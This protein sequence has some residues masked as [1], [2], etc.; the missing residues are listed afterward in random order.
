MVS[1]KTFR[2]LTTAIETICE[3]I[4]TIKLQMGQKA[5]VKEG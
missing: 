3:N 2:M 5:I 1:V 4:K